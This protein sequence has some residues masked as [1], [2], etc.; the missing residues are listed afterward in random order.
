MDLWQLQFNY[1]SDKTSVAEAGHDCLYQPL[2]K[3]TTAT[4]SGL[5]DFRDKLMVK[6][7]TVASQVKTVS[8]FVDAC[9][10]HTQTTRN[11]PFVVPVVKKQCMS[12]LLHQWVHDNDTPRAV[13]EDRWPH[14][15]QQCDWGPEFEQ[16]I[17]KNSSMLMVS[18]EDFVKSLDTS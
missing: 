6:L 13:D 18:Y 14:L 17:S 16:I 12:Q 10:K 1:F 9:F 5:Q 15:D 3:C 8:L 11:K 7:K 4:F 2:R